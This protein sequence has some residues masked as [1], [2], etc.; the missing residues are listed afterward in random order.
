[1]NVGQH[2]IRPEAIDGQGAL[3]IA[4]PFTLTLAVAVD[5]Q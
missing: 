2:F 5:Q 3:M 4:G 1:L